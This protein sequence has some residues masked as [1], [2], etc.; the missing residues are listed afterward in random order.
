[1]HALLRPVD[2]LDLMEFASDVREVVPFTNNLHQIDSGL[3]TAAPGEATA[4]YDTIFLASQTLGGP[5][6]TQGAGADYGR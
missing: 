1:M 2:Q 5:A 4:L 3:R 6:R